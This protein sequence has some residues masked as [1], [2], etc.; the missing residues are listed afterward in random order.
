MVFRSD[1]TLRRYC[2]QC[3]TASFEELE[4]ATRFRERWLFRTREVSRTLPVRYVDEVARLGTLNPQGGHSRDG[5]EEQDGSRSV[6][7]FGRA[8]DIE[9][10]WTRCGVWLECQGLRSRRTFVRASSPKTIEVEECVWAIRR[11]RAAWGNPSRWHT[12][13]EGNFKFTE[14]IHMKEGRAALMGL[15]RAV[16]GTAGHG[17]RFLSFTDNMSS[18]LAFDRGRSCI[19][20]L[21]CLCRRAA[22]LCIGADVSWVLR[23]LEIWR[24]PSDEGSRRVP[25][26]GCGLCGVLPNH[27]RPN[28][29]LEFWT[30]KFASIES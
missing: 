27:S 10:A 3:S 7:G 14:A 5:P 18:L 6:T 13:I 25:R 12:I 24:N 1:A 9:E 8:A 29:F 15:R 28:M 20:D 23:H 30:F 22:A 2:V 21:L 26:F 19:Y 4:E 17:H 11:L 16:A